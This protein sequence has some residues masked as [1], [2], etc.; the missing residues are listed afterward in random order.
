MTWPPLAEA[1]GALAFGPVRL[2]APLAV[3]V[4]ARTCFGT[5]GR[6][7]NTN[8]IRFVPAPTHFGNGAERVG[9]ARQLSSDAL[10]CRGFCRASAV[11]DG[12]S[13]RLSGSAAVSRP[14]REWRRPRVARGT[15]TQSASVA[16][17]TRGRA[18]HLPFP[19]GHRNPYRSPRETRKRQAAARETQSPLTRDGFIV[20]RCLS[21]LLR[22]TP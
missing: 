3:C 17:R 9:A 5:C 8:I 13:L 10:P 1:S 15:T 20:S 14:K 18:L 16:R 11:A 7:R 6:E 19:C 22:E 21:C 2:R 4:S 12:A